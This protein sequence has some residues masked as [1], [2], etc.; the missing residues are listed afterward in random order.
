MHQVLTGINIYNAIIGKN[1]Q[2][3][4]GGILGLEYQ[5]GCQL[6][7]VGDNAVIWEGTIIYRDVS[8]G[9]NFEAGHFVL[10]REKMQLGNNV[11]VGTHSVIEGHCAM[12]DNIRFQTG[13]Y[14]PMFT[15]MSSRSNYREEI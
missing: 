8:I 10:I 7:K 14:I 5:K 1:C 13:V 6:A 9:D 12:G 2:V 4:D 3:A 15:F 11:L